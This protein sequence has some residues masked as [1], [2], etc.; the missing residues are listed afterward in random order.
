MTGRLGRARVMVLMLS[1]PIV[2][3]PAL[4][5]SICRCGDP[6]YNALGNEGIA[7]EG[8]RL[9]LDWDRVEKTQGGGGEQESL[10][11][12]R[13]TL[14]A[15]FGVSEAVGV[16]LRVPF[17]QRRLESHED[18]EAGQVA[19]SGLAD[20]EISLQWRLWSSA[21]DGEVGTRSRV[22]LTGGVKTDWGENDESAGGERLD[23]HVQPGTGATDEFI[24]IAA[25]RQVDPATALFA[26]VQ[27][28]LTGRNDHGYRYGRSTLLNVA[29]DRRLGARW[30]LVVEANYR[31]AGRDEI[32]GQGTRDPDTGGAI[33]YLTPRMLFDLGHGWV[34]R[35]S[36]Q[37]P[38][39]QHGL[40][41]DQHERAVLN[42]GATYLPRR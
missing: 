15:A 25:S 21:F 9:A 38:L 27:H 4:G 20:P 37:L 31:Q 12:R 5:C 6:T 35:A 40:N 30:D 29:Y 33:T 16:F 1:L 19:V 2:A 24:G 18:G 14:L 11:E 28:R 8:W 23:E 17:S 42:V 22:Y 36:A 39:Y 26:S 41:G 13:T 10:T 7:Q 3:T 34:L 32:D